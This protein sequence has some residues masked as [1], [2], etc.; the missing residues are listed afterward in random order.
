MSIIGISPCI[1][2]PPPPPVPCAFAGSVTA[3]VTIAELAMAVSARDAPLTN[4]GLL[5]LLNSLLTFLVRSLVKRLLD[6]IAKFPRIVR[7]CRL[8]D[9]LPGLLLG[10]LPDLASVVNEASF[11]DGIVFSIVF[12]SG[13]SVSL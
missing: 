1:R 9:L 6:K 11:G 7:V 3:S 2:E 12:F 4:E 13:S 8:P 10:L 5:G